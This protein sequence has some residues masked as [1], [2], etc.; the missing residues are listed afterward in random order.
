MNE[1][2]RAIIIGATSGIGLAVARQLSRKGWQIG[3]AGRR[4]QLLQEIQRQDLNIVATQCIDVTSED[5]VEGL[6]TLIGKTGGM[7]LYF[8]SSGIG[9]QNPLLDFE[10]E[11]NTVQT[12]AVGFTR[13]VLTAFKYYQEHSE[14]KGH[15]AVISSI[16]GT[17]GLGA[18]PSYS[19]TK[20]Y[21]NHYLECLV[22]LS[23]IKG[24]KNLTISDIRP[25]FVRT[26]LLKDGGDYPFQLD[27]EKV[28]AEI[29]RG[30]EKKKSI[31]TVDWK[32]RIIVFFWR[33]VPRWIWVRMNVV[34][35]KKLIE[36]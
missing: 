11:M 35:K 5:A 1:P 31:I 32:Y 25:G 29:I 10:K 36:K 21:V 24:M 3:I 9:Y 4:Q 27:V 28:A 22:Q 6:K 7:D 13:M 20:R 30:L 2:K 26:P 14:I 33:L 16:A 15:I 12:N 18:A 34:N 23:H 19:S 17:K 8:H